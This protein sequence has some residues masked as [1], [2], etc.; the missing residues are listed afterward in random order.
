MDFRFVRCFIYILIFFA[1]GGSAFFTLPFIRCYKVLTCPG[2]NLTVTTTTT[3][4]SLIDPRT[5]TMR[6]TELP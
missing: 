4:E 1:P 2:L 6:P 5:T 3:P